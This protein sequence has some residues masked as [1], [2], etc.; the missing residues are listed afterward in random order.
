MEADFQRASN[1]SVI[2]AKA[3]CCPEYFQTLVAAYDMYRHLA[4]ARHPGAGR[5]NLGM[6]LRDEGQSA[7][8]TRRNEKA[9]PFLVATTYPARIR[10]VIPAQAGIQ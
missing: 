9:T 3:H 5:N 8:F 1:R 2:P 10:L 6:V 7:I 4:L